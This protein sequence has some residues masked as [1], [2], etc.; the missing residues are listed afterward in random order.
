MIAGIVVAVGGAAVIAGVFLAILLLWR[1]RK[2]KRVKLDMPD[3]SNIM[4]SPG[5]MDLLFFINNCQLLFLIL[6]VKVRA[7]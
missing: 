1:K 7:K 4:F 6:Q 5:I 2:G 3:F